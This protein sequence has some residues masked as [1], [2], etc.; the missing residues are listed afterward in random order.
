LNKKITTEIL[1]DFSY[2]QLD[3]FALLH[4]SH[5]PMAMVQMKILLV[6]FDRK[7]VKIFSMST[8]AAA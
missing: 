5:H 6:R 8:M 1:K 4:A 2:R 7:N 3:D